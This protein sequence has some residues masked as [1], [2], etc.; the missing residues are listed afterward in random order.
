MT[1]DMKTLFAI[2]PGL[3]AG[4]VVATASAVDPQNYVVTAEPSAIMVNFA[5]GADTRGFAWQTDA[6]VTNGE[7]RLVRGTV[8]SDA[9]FERAAL[10]FPAVSKR[11]KDPDLV[12]HRAFAIGLRLG[13][14]YSYRLGVPGH[15]AYGTVEVKAPSE[16]VT[17]LNLNDAQTKRMETYPVWENTLAAAAKTVGAGVDFILNGGDLMDGWFKGGT[18]RVYGRIGR[19]LEWALAVESAGPFF[20]GVPWMSSSGNHDFWM[21]STF[22]AVD[23]PKGLP[24]GCESLD[25]G[26][27]H[28]VAVPY[29]PGGWTPRHEAVYAWL[30]KDLAANRKRLKND[31]TVVAIHWGPYTTGDHGAEPSV[32]NV[33]RRL[34]PLF[35]SNRVDLVLQAHDHTY[36][37]TLP[38][39]WTGAGF[40]TNRNDRTAVNTSP[41]RL[42]RREIAYDH[43]PNGTYY[44]SCGAAGHRVGE[45]V[46]Y[47]APTGTHSFTT[48]PYWIAANALAVDSPWGRKGDVASADL[49]RSMF[50]VLRVEGRRLVYEAYVVGTNGTATLYD[51]LRISKE[52]MPEVPLLSERQKTLLNDVPENLSGSPPAFDDVDYRAGIAAAGWHPQPVRLSYG[53]RRYNG[54]RVT[55]CEAANGALAWEGAGEGWFADVWNL[56]VGTAYDWSVADSSGCVRA[57]GSFVTENRAPRLMKVDG[58]PNVRDLGGWRG[59]DGRRIR[60]GLVYR[61]AGFNGNATADCYDYEDVRRLWSE[62]RLL[63][64]FGSGPESNDVRRL[65]AHLESGD[66]DVS[67][68]VRYM[69]P[70]PNGRHAGKTRLNEATRRYLAETLGIRSDIDLRGGRE[71]WGMTGSPL[72]PGVRWFHC[73]ARVYGDMGSEEGRRRFAQA[74]RVFLDPA[75][76]PIAF[77]CIGGQDRTGSV[78]CILEALLGVSEDDLWRDWQLS[79]LYNDRSRFG[80]ASGTRRFE[81]LLD[82]LKA[83]PGKTL[84]EKAAAYVKSCG[85]TDADIVALREQLLEPLSSATDG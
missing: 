28:I 40:T 33:I 51:T 60:Q 36:S 22:M 15:Y 61:T 80:G 14:D 79:A 50:G 10:V 71:T 8:A 45:N 72:G 11:V 64:L 48:R 58:V 47:A 32:S 78:A 83:Y 62:G 21:Y 42:H 84:A 81:D 35:A 26:N 31:W 46:A 66:V 25:Y 17:I 37:K 44:L 19:P 68:D 75:N 55:V 30:A 74:L 52:S 43:H 54:D 59:L 49:P 67:R 20:P 77:H 29:V 85:F 38:Y 1:T 6:S 73:P 2:F 39:R 24:P 82:V 57:R 65:I 53:G 70:K 69:F 63:S 41:L 13:E 56:K 9:D 16:S 7:L 12:R 5:S 18:N 4:S 27:V 76:Y 3:L 23:Y 34:T